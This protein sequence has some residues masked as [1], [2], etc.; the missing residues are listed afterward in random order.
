MLVDQQYGVGVVVGRDIVEAQRGKVVLDQRDVRG[1]PGDPLV[2]VV[3]GLQIRQV[4]EAEQG[5][6][7]GV[8]DRPCRL[9]ESVEGF[10]DQR[11]DVEGLIGRCSDADGTR[12]QATRRAWIR[13]QVVGEQGVQVEKGTPVEVD[14]V[15]AV[16]RG[17]SMARLWLRIICVSRASRFRP[18]APG[19]EQPLRV[20]QGVRVALEAARIPG[21]VD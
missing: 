11:R 1:E 18:S 16:P 9:E 6:L 15:D 13:Q 3:E 12:T 8:L 10:G 14:L 5:L 2:H 21:K 19:F 20:Q 17:N 4:H 7:D